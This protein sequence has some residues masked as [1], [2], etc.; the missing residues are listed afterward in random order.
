MWPIASYQFDYRSCAIDYTAMRPVVQ[1]QLES[2]RFDRGGTCPLRKL[3]L[4]RCQ[5]VS[6]DLQESYLDTMLVCFQ[7]GESK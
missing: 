1:H 4:G 7:V 2:S 3:F 5:H 6:K